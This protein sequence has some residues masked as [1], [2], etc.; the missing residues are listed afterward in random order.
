MPPTVNRSAV[1]IT[2]KQPF[3]DWLHS[4]D[5]ST[6]GT[7]LDDLR[8]PTLYLLP[9]CED[10]QAV[11]VYLRDYCSNIFRDQLDNWYVQRSTW[12][13]DMGFI[14]FCHWFEYRVYTVLRDLYE[15]PLCH[16]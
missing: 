9:D 7:T 8:E 6:S 14:V 15:R 13:P 12:P 10:D 5:P 2:P 3:L 1:V 11:A 16:D 4:N